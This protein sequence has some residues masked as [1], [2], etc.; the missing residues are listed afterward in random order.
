MDFH[1]KGV[2]CACSH[3]SV[4]DSSLQCVS[5]CCAFPCCVCQPSAPAPR[6][7]STMCVSG[8]SLL[9]CPAGLLPFLH[10]KLSR[11]PLQPW[12][13][14]EL[15]FQLCQGCA[16]Y[17]NFF[18]FFS[19][20]TQHLSSYR[21]RVSGPSWSQSFSHNFPCKQRSLPRVSSGLMFGKYLVCCRKL[22][23]NIHVL[24]Q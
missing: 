24:A 20:S 14:Q 9:S 21:Q 16:I 3:Q 18:F 8:T 13:L 17:F 1:R 7:C 4:L 10:H 5:V 19:L 11:G 2:L 22:R 15:F 6:T 23:S 12:H